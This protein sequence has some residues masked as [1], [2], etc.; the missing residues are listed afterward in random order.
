MK[1]LFVHRDLVKIGHY[2]SIL[3]C[4]GIRTVT[5]NDIDLGVGHTMDFCYPELWVDEEAHALISSF[6]GSD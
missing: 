1:K 5:K 3:E 2:A 4:R 6:E